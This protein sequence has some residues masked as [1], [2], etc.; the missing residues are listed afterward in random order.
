MVKAS[1]GD[2]VMSAM[3]AIAACAILVYIVYAYNTSRT[4]N[5]DGGMAAGTAAGGIP[6]ASEPAASTYQTVDYPQLPPA[7][8]PV[9]CFPKD[10]LTA[11]D[12]LPK[13]AVN[14]QW[15]QAN[16][17]GQGDVS[18]QNFLTAGHFAGLDTIGGTLRIPSMDLRST[19]P[20]PQRTV[21]IWN[22][23]TVEPDLNR[24]PL[25]IGTC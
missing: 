1:S 8:A 22:Q 3:I 13:D 7:E 20:N 18:D 19:P 5:F 24:R 4:D 6:Q 2:G 16:P 17:A 21:S 23:S 25:E 15:A 10:R 14:E 11:A 9:D 12:L